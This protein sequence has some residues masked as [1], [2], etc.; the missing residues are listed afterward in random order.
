MNGRTLLRIVVAGLLVVLGAGGAYARPLG[1]IAVSP[2]T[3]TVYFDGEAFEVTTSASITVQLAF[4]SDEMLEGAVVVS[5]GSAAQV[6]I[7]WRDTGLTVF[8]GRV[9][10][11]APIRFPIPPEYQAS[12]DTGHT[13]K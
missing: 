10:I 7:V 3:S 5:G 4:T 11:E 13:E 2:G 8:S 12:L 9:V 1:T 6:A